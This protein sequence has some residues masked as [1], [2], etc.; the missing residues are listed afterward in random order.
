MD[1][2]FRINKPSI[3]SATSPTK[4]VQLNDDDEDDPFSPS[5]PKNNS[6]DV[7][8][9][10]TK[11]APTIET[12]VPASSVV[13]PTEVKVQTSLL[14]Q[15][16]T[17][18]KDV[19]DVSAS[20]QKQVIH[21]YDLFVVAFFEINFLIYMYLYLFKLDFGSIQFHLFNETRRRRRRSR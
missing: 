19:S 14:S 1:E 12:N 21:L 8:G 10:E 6:A 13:T 7:N 2:L 18:S 16:S 5:N 3:T 20:L 11:P 9:I 4:E 17:D 15:K